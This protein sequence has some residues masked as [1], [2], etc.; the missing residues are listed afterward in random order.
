VVVFLA[1]QNSFS[2]RVLAM[3]GS[4]LQ[5]RLRIKEA[6][7]RVNDA[8]IAAA[9]TWTA[10]RLQLIARDLEDTLVRLTPDP[11]ALQPTASPWTRMRR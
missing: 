11:I 1:C 10:S 9:G 2:L 3:T 8:R 5:V 7:A 4:D 6:L